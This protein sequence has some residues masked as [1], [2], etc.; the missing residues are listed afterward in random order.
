MKAD[1]MALWR[2]I[3]YK[4]KLKIV[5]HQQF[6]FVFYEHAIALSQGFFKYKIKTA[7]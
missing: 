4:E 5:L 3:G 1:V 2:R 6:F 7:G